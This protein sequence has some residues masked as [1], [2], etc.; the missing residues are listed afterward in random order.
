MYYLRK[1]IMRSKVEERAFYM[2]AADKKAM[3]DLPRT[4]AN[5]QEKTGKMRPGK[6]RKDRALRG[7]S[8]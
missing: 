8:S 7:G 4:H 6:T 3:G 2:T 5:C 1:V